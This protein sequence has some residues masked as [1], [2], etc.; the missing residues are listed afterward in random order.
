[1]ITKA[2]IQLVRSLSDKRN[3]EEQGLFVAEGE[4]LISEIRSSK[5]RIRRIYALEGLFRGEEVEVVTPK[6]LERMTQLKTANNSLA[7]VE[8]PHHQLRID[9]L[10]GRLSLALDQVQ[11]PGNLGTIVRLADWFGIEHIFC[12]QGTVDVYNPKTVQ[13][14]M[15]ALA[16]VKLHYCNLPSLISS[17][18]D[19]PVYGT[20]L[21]GK[22]M[23]GEALSANGLIVMGNEGNG[24]GQEVASLI[25]RKLYIPNYPPQRETTE[26]LNVAMATGII[27]AEFRRR[28][29]SVG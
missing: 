28:A 22:D 29:I 15:G 24:I 26:S 10:K 17:L 25:N 16:R 7:L 3:R 13:A 2:E 1:M 9:D 12:S 23:Y 5:L 11:N 4:K 8:I 27:C 20:F 14:T 21:D 6:E 19:V 18:K